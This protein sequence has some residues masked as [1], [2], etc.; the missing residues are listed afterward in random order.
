MI[1]YKA[2][3]KMVIGICDDGELKL[4]MYDEEK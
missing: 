4:M 1:E 3:R 2:G